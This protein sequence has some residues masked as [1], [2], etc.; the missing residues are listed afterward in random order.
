MT[1]R[2]TTFA[3]GQKNAKSNMLALILRRSVKEKL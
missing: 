2:P 3:G 1:Y